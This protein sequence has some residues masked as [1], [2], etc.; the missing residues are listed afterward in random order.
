MSYKFHG[1]RQFD[2]TDST[3]KCYTPEIHQIQ[4]SNFSVQLQIKPKSEFD[5]VPRDT[6][7]TEF[8]DAE[9]YGDAAL[10]VESVMYL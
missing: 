1:K 3:L 5:F 4:T 6:Q 9:D 7:K 2:M 8:F 10:S